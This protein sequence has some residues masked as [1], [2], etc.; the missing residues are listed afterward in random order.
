MIDQID[1]IPHPLIFQPDDQQIAAALIHAILSFLADLSLPL[2]PTTSLSDIVTAS[3]L[4]LEMELLDPSRI[5][6]RSVRRLALLFAAQVVTA[7]EAQWGLFQTIRDDWAT[8][9]DSVGRAACPPF[10]P[11]S[12]ASPPIRPKQSQHPENLVDHTEP[13]H[14]HLSPP[15]PKPVTLALPDPLH[16]RFA[17]IQPPSIL[18]VPLDPSQLTLDSLRY[19]HPETGR[20]PF[21]GADRRPFLIRSN[22]DS[23]GGRVPDDLTPHKIA[24]ILGRDE[25]MSVQPIG[26]WR[27][28]DA[29]KMAIGTFCDQLV[30]GTAKASLLTLTAHHESALG[31]LVRPPQ[32]AFDLHNGKEA[33]A[34]T[35][36]MSPAGAFTPWHVD[37]T[38]SSGWTYIPEGQG[39]AKVWYFAAPTA[40]NLAQA[41]RSCGPDGPGPT[42]LQ[43]QGVYAIEQRAGDILWMPSGFLHAV[44]TIEPTCMFTGD[45]MT[46][47]DYPSRE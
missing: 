33:P 26:T 29:E 27:V 37:S 46:S 34:C 18:N 24:E 36:I 39:G 45:F 47:F 28:H 10:T 35:I 23:V 21:F 16:P 30:A 5:S 44:Y 3:S 41:V 2:G 7:A 31:R 32:F 9:L 25:Q 13:P 19:G 12:V 22:I 14:D 43:L 4:E 6:R 38:G 1:P 20:P 42:T 40:E 17:D 11:I 15:A 8:V